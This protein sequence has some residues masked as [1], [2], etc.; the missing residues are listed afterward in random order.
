ML[1]T[2]RSKSISMIGFWKCA[3]ALV[4]STATL[5]LLLLA[6]APPAGSAAQHNPNRSEGGAHCKPMSA[7]FWSASARSPNGITFEILGTVH[8]ARPAVTDVA[9]ARCWIE[10]FDL[11]MLEVHPSVPQ[12]EANHGYRPCVDDRGVRLWH[13]AILRSF[14]SIYRWAALRPIPT[15]ENVAGETSARLAGFEN[16][17]SQL[18]MLDKVS[19]D[20]QARMLEQAVADAQSGAATRS[21]I[22]LIRAYDQNRIAELE[23]VMQSLGNDDLC[24]C[25]G[26]VEPI[27]F[28]ERNARFSDVMTALAAPT[29]GKV[30]V[31]VGIGHLFGRNSLLNHLRRAGFKV[32]PLSH[33]WTN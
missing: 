10:R 25:K 9:S 28:D 24:N 23:D 13:V 19:C 8:G 16:P 26:I 5:L 15:L 29:R 17:A 1:C 12:T 31:L 22:R 27:M 33:K 11:V 2:C 20:V 18:A 6:L 4:Q 3:Q 32:G 14:Q 21:V 7:S 30:L